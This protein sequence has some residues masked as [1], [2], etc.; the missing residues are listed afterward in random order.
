M[1]LQ[2]TVPTARLSLAVCLSALMA[3][4]SLN[5]GPSVLAVESPQEV[6]DR[7]PA[8]GP[9]EDSY[10]AVIP[11]AYIDPDDLDARAPQ[12]YTVVRGDT[13][14]DISDR[15]LKRPWMWPQIWS[16]NPQI[17]NPHLIYPGDSLTLDYI[18]GRPSLALTR[19]STTMLT[20]LSTANPVVLDA[21]GNPLSNALG[22]AG[23]RERLSPRIRSESLN[24]AVPTIPG[25]AI[26]QFLVHPLVVDADTLADAPYVVGNVD[27]RLISAVGHKVFVRGRLTRAK[28]YYGIY[29]HSKELRDPMNGVLLGFEI[30]HIADA[31]LLNVGDPSTLTITSN[32][33][34]TMTGDIVLP[35]QEGTVTHSYVP[36]LPELKGSGRVVSLVNAISQTGRNQVVVLNIGAES[37]VQ[38]GDVLAIE[39]RGKELIDTRGHGGNERVTLPNQRIGV[40]MVFKTF[41]KVSYALVMEST[42]PVMMNDIITGI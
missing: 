10:A 42:R 7:F 3:A 41:D 24:D 25:D 29:R 40:V 36:R 15:F 2:S 39:T 37:S 34:E 22:D 6:T 9:S 12:E 16:S 38:A 32:K 23:A 11:R 14:W 5:Q 26:Q 18:G 8:A 21:D 13:L 20:A 35:S 31:K 30:T 17:D 27:N 1:A 4:C 33:M 19:H 28:T